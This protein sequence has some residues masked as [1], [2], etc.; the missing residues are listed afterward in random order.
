MKFLVDA[1]SPYSLIGIFD[2]YSYDAIHVRDI[3]K[4]ASDDEIFEYANKN[5]YIIVTKDLGFAKMFM[6]GRGVGL[7]LIRLPYYFTVSKIVKIFDEFIK[8]VDI[9]K[10]INSIT[11]LE[12]GRYRTKRIKF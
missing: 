7:I 3:L 6:E 5:R 2:K 9:K 12:L 10:L 4:F 8:E 1:D 11:I